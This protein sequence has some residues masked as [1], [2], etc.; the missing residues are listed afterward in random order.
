M[1]L[2]KLLRP[3]ATLSL[4]LVTSSWGLA[5]ESWLGKR[6]FFKENAVARDGSSLSHISAGSPIQDMDDEGVLVAGVWVQKK[7]VMLVDEAIQHYTR[8]WEKNP[9]QTGYLLNRAGAWKFKGD[10]D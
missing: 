2:E 6:A 10:L 7:H 1:H 4:L 8:G 5:A 3:V 9:K